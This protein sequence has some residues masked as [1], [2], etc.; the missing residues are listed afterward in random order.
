VLSDVL[1]DMTERGQIPENITMDL[2]SRM[3]YNGPKKFWNV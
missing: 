1:G 3:A 2:A